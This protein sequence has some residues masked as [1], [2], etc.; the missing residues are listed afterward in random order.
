MPNY[1]VGDAP[2]QRPPYPSSVP[3]P[4]DDQADPE[5]LGERDDLLSR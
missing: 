5:F 1:P 3:A 4:H 2:G